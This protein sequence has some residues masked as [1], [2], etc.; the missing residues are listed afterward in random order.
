[1]IAEALYMIGHVSYERY[2]VGKGGGMAYLPRAKL[3]DSLEG[4]RRP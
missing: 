4:G 1:M 2:I 3:N